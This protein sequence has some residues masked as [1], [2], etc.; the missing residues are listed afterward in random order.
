MNPKT[1]KITVQS[2]DENGCAIVQIQSDNR[3]IVIYARKDGTA[4]VCIE[5][6]SG[7]RLLK[8]DFPYSEPK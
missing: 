4:T 2:F 6:C 8:L 5:D 3:S 1:P 7:L